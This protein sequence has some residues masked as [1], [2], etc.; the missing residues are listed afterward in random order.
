MTSL[1]VAVVDGNAPLGQ[2]S[3]AVLHDL[4]SEQHEAQR[5]CGAMTSR[6]IGDGRWSRF[7]FFLGQRQVGE[8]GSFTLEVVWQIGHTVIKT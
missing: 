7:V 8:R 1:D 3:K 4:F 2:D 6:A 5:E